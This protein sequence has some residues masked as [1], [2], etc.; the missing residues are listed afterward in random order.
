MIIIIFEIIQEGNLN[1][2][3]KLDEG[4]QMDITTVPTFI[5]ELY[6]NKSLE[7]KKVSS[8]SFYYLRLR[9]KRI[10]RKRVHLLPYFHN[11]LNGFHKDRRSTY[12]NIPFSAN[13]NHYGIV[14]NLMD[15]WRTWIQ[16]NEAN[17]RRL[18]TYTKVKNPLEFCTNH[19]LTC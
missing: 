12:Y 19:P 17:V 14:W 11:R 9:K 18:T 7:N 2:R 5:S 3:I 16:T 1:R 4:K 6:R 15:I 8:H 13:T 10:L